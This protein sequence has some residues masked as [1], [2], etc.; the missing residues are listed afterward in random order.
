MFGTSTVEASTHVSIFEGGTIDHFV[1][2]DG[3]VELNFSGGDDLTL[4]LSREAFERLLQAWPDLVAK[5]EA[6][7]RELDALE[8]TE[9]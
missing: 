1:G 4:A 2:R 8:P 3:T 7:N 5:V 6:R 9:A